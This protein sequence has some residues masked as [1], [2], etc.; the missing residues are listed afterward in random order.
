MDDVAGS[1]HQQPDQSAPGTL[2][3]GNGTS[4]MDAQSASSGIHVHDNPGSK[5]C[6]SSASVAVG[7]LPNNNNTVVQQAASQA[8]LPPCRLDNLQSVLGDPSPTAE[9]YRLAPDSVVTAVRIDGSTV[10]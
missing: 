10:P 2:S 5:V 9:Q 7:T 1:E 8:A 4:S 3:A 6:P